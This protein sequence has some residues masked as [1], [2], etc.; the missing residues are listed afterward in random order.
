MLKSKRSLK[1]WIAIYSVR[2]SVRTSGFQPEKRGSTPLP[3]TILK[4]KSIGMGWIIKQGLPTCPSCRWC[5]LIWYCKNFI[6][7]IIRCQQEKVTLSRFL[8]RTKTVKG[9]RVQL[10]AA[11]K[12][13]RIQ[14]CG[15]GQLSLVTYRVLARAL[16]K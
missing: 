11:R 5:I 8:R 10:P 3:S 1:T 2:L 7:M 15:T 14:D 13:R 4:C 9:I 12:D 16:C 6:H